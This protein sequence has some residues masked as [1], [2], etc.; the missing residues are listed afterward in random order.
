MF[1]ESES[2]IFEEKKYTLSPFEN[3]VEQKTIWLA[4]KKTSLDLLSQQ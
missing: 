4:V 2:E 1:W 3:M